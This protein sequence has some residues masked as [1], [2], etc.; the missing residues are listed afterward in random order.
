M[1]RGTEGPLLDSKHDP[2]DALDIVMCESYGTRLSTHI[3][4][5][6][7]PSSDVSWKGV[8]SVCLGDV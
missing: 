2:G 7:V 8:G 1:P 3:S 4:S 6:L 5:L